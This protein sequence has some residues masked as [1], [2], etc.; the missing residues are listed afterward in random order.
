M[1]PSRKWPSAA[2]SVIMLFSLLIIGNSKNNASE[3]NYSTSEHPI[4]KNIF[5]QSEVNQSSLADIAGQSSFNASEKNNNA[6]TSVI[7]TSNNNNET[8]LFIAYNKVQQ[9]RPSEKNDI[10]IADENDNTQSEFDDLTL[11]YLKDQ[12]EKPVKTIALPYSVIN[13]DKNSLTQLFS[14]KKN[15]KFSLDYYISPTLNY[16]SLYVQNDDNTGT[17]IRVFTPASNPDKIT[18]GFEAGGRISYSLSENLKIN[19]GVQLNYSGYNITASTTHPT[20]ASVM[21]TNDDGTQR[22]FSGI[23]N[24][25]NTTSGS[26]VTLHNYSLQASV[27]IGLQ[28]KLAGNENI[29]VVADAA[30]QPFYVISSNAYIL[31]S[32]KR[33]F[34]SDP[35]LL[36]DFNISTQFG[37]SLQFRS[38]NLNWQI[39]PQFRYQLM[40]TYSRSVPYKEH[41]INYGIRL[42]ISPLSH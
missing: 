6:Q 30:F 34:I 41:L 25:T 1:H 8:S 37:T 39:G 22:I 24:Y 29:S 7:K 19:T 16:R 23:S 32:D 17:N 21:I 26:P 4:N 3:K 15:S 2:M 38:N 13:A 12:Q 9:V 36:R 14:K 11:H 42:G 20:Y 33:N 35:S 18:L 10:T 27:P 40:S 31:S 5:S 28:Y